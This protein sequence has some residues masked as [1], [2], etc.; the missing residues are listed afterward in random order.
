MRRD[1]LA[2]LAQLR[3]LQTDA[4]RRTLADREARLV[5]AEAHATSAAAALA[6]ESA[7]AAPE[8]YAAWL[9]RAL[10]A[11]ER[12]ARGT[13]LAVRASASARQALIEARTGERVLELLQAGQAAAIRKAR[14]RREQVMLDA[15]GANRHMRHV[16]ATRTP[17]G[18]NGGPH[19]EEAPSCPTVSPP[20]RARSPAT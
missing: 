6:H 11:R 16:T 18:H 17:Q 2:A 20:T 7:D 19:R 1:P 8:A 12:A 3:R 13:A 5:Q 4:A 10:A 9:P 15:F 14:A